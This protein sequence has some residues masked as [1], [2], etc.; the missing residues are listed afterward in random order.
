MLRECFEADERT[1]FVSW[2]PV[3]HD[4]GLITKLITSFCCGGHCVL[5]SPFSFL[6]KPA[7]WL[8]TIA[9]FR[10]NVS[11][12][13]DFAFAQCVRRVT[14]EQCRGLDLSSWRVAFVGA[15]PVRPATLRA[16]A[17]RFG[18]FGFREHA[19][20][21]G[22]GLAEATVF[23]SAGSEPVPPTVL[24]V[25]AAAF[26]RGRIALARGGSTIASVS[27]G[28]VSYGRQSVRIV[29]PVTATERAP[30]EIGEIWVAGDHV[31]R[32][33]WN[34]H[35]ATATTF[36]ARLSDTGDGPFLR[37]GDL[38]FLHNGELHVAGRIKD[39]II[40]DG[41]NHFPQD[42]E[43]TVE[44]CHE[45][46]RSGGVAAFSV[47]RGGEEQ[48]IVL[49]ELL[50]PPDRYAPADRAA[51]GDAVRSAVSAEH[52]IRLSDVWLAGAGTIS[53]TT[54]GKVERQ[55]CRRDY[56]ARSEPTLCDVP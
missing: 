29:D 18:D 28:R 15:E 17:D 33:Y 35:Q 43:Q 19:L 49:V 26:E 48:V 45:S 40:V 8:D 27:C 41:S 53:R 22:Y 12:G 6:R 54:S 46:I 42:I 38:G 34:D 4:M 30:S 25:D 56:M 24:D 23:V 5:M 7:R 2:L 36:R 51:I 20:R 31:T 16:F 50:Q 52:G 32:G 21:P 10:A 3:F 14:D 9:R 11:G 55:A 1:V 44:A 37:T 39:L 47:Q 13:P